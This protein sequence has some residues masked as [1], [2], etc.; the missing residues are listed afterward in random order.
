MQSVTL[1]DNMHP[2]E[3]LIYLAIAIALILFFQRSF[4]A[5]RQAHW[6]H[7][8]NHILSKARAFGMLL[9]R[10]KITVID[11]VY[12]S[13]WAR[14]SDGRI[15]TEQVTASKNLAPVRIVLEGDDR[16]DAMRL[17]H[18]SVGS[19]EMTRVLSAATLAVDTKHWTDATD[20]LRD[21]YQFSKKQGNGTYAPIGFT[22]TQIIDLMIANRPL[23]PAPLG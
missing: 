10:A 16:A 23:P 21:N 18:A 6:I 17:L 8:E 13:Q 5:A 4:Y 11:G 20:W 12:F 1:A 14:Y 7:E 9:D 2:I 22:L 3:A 15:V 19:G